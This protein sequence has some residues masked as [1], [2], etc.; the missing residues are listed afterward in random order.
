MQTGGILYYLFPFL[1]LE[2]DLSRLGVEFAFL[3]FVKSSFLGFLKESFGE[4][5]LPDDLLLKSF[6]LA[7]SKDFL[8]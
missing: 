7:L 4:N 6:Y 2:G 1:F 5:F 8:S 3:P